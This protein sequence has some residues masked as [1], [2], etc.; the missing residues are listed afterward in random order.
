MTPTAAA[1]TS[2]SVI[3]VIIQ[4]WWLAFV[5]FPLIGS[6]FEGVRDFFVDIY[7]SIMEAR[8][9]HEV[10]KIKAQKKLAK[11]QEE[12]A[13]V[14]GPCRHVHVTPVVETKK[15]NGFE[16]DKVVAWLCKNEYCSAQLPPDWATRK[17]DLP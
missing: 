1:A 13:L 14:P 3:D 17:E 8:T 5:I 10:A 12:P 4:Y 15:V 6:F 11:A 9:E 7:V 2:P 16:E